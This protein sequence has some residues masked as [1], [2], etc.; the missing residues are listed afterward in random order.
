MLVSLLIPFTLQDT[1]TPKWRKS[2]GMNDGL[3]LVKN[4]KNAVVCLILP[5]A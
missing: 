1:S 2:V 5:R 3:D 4:I